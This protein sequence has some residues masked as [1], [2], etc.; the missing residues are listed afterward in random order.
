MQQ[1]E[2][3]TLFDKLDGGNRKKDINKKQCPHNN[4]ND[5]NNCCEDCG[6]ELSKTIPFDKEWR[7][8]GHLDNRNINDPNR[9]HIR[10]NEDKTIYKDISNLSLPDNI[11]KEAN[12]LYQHVVKDRIYRGNT[13][14]SIIFACIFYAYKKVGNPQSCDILTSLFNLDKKDGLKGLKI[15]N[16]NSDNTMIKK[17]TY[18]TPINLINEIMTQFDAN[19]EDKDS[20]I[21]LYHKI[22]GRSEVLSRARPQS[23]AAGLI[24]YYIIKNDRDIS[25]TDF[26]EKVNLS[27]L[28]INRIVREITNIIE[29]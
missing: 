6:L 8:Y 7:Y 2:D 29:S 26:R 21:K 23:V 9:C 5:K 28:T 24:R 19:Q 3:F 16:L 20:V 1:Q 18:I 4:L 10:K 22:Q 14:K 13:R 27:D 15:V 11:V 17:S 12:S 25:M